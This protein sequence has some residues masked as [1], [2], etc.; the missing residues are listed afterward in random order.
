MEHISAQ[1][2]EDR[3][4]E[5]SVQ[6][7][8]IVLELCDHPEIRARAAQAPKQFGILVCAALLNLA[9]SGHD[10]GPRKIVARKSVLTGEVAIAAAE[11][12]PG[13][14]GG[15][16]HPESRGQP[17]FLRLAKKFAQLES[18]LATRY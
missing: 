12:E 16:G 1:R 6:R 3:S 13:D 17:V 15:R 4:A 8:Q 7:M 10:L 18:R 11:C 5:H 14:S 2:I 9:V